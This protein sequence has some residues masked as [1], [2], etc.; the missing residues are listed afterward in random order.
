MPKDE[1]EGFL[2]SYSRWIGGEGGFIDFDKVT[3][4][5]PDRY[6]KY[7]DIRCREDVHL[8]RES[9]DK[10]AVVKLA[11]GLG[12]S[13]KCSHAK[14]TLPVRD[15]KTFLDLIVEQLIWINTKYT[16]SIPLVLMTSFATHDELVTAC[17]KYEGK[18]NIM[19]FKQSQYPRVDIETKQPLWEHAGEKC[20]FCPPGHGDLILKIKTSGIAQKLFDSGKRMLFVA[21]SD[22]LGA[23]VDLK[24]LSLLFGC[25][26]GQDIEYLME[27]TPKTFKDVKGG[28]LV[29]LDGKVKLMELAQVDPKHHDEFKSI[30]R[31]SV[32]NTNNV[33]IRLENLLHLK[34][35]KL[36][37]ILNKKNVHGR[38]VLQFETAIG[39]AISEFE[40]AGIV[41]PRKRFLPVKTTND[42]MVVQS[43]CFDVSEGGFLSLSP[44][45]HQIPTVRL[46]PSFKGVAEFES[47]F[48]DGIPSLKF[49][50]FFC[51]D[52][53]V[54][55]KSPSL[56]G[57]I[58]IIAEEKEEEE[59]LVI[60]SPIENKII[61]HGEECPFF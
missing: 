48:P 19:F 25:E 46:G 9:L 55:I 56:K 60:T 50:Q 14:V 3:D 58:I 8:L 61:R 28:T 57:N 22:N 16:V 20:F 23:T 40:G 52:G 2:H 26:E 21:N 49:C 15:G 51:V 13:M 41:V 33:W 11:G 53:D 32:F 4:V 54:T 45:C 18:L 44:L 43:D 27:V 42:L 5:E 30:E 38:D 1:V 36:D 6:Y 35:P 29:S 34:H 24:I 39:S 59:P 37:L 17:K 7:E 12:T 47:R 10:L 31:F